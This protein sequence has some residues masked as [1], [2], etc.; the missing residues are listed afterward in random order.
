M[1]YRISEAAELLGVSSDT[2]RRWT[3]QGRVPTARDEGRLT[4]EGVD[5]AR[6]ATELADDADRTEAR[7]SSVSARNRLVGIVT[8]VRADAVMAQV[9]VVCGPY[10]IVSLLS[11]DAVRDLGL[12]P[13][14]RAVASVKSTNVVLER[15]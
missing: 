12:E 10:R 8:D 14:V 2:L 7:A 9:E 11:A 5:L 4:V 13:G 3:E 1:R 15:P 6:L